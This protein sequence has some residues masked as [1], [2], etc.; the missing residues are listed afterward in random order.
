[1]G[2]A[3]RLSLALGLVLPV[4][5]SP[6]AS[7][8]WMDSSSR[9]ARALAVAA[10]AAGSPAARAGVRVGDAVRQVNGERPHACEAWRVVL[11]NAAERGLAVLL[12]SGRGR[13]TRVAALSATAL[14]AAAP[15]AEPT[16]DVVPDAAATAAGPARVRDVLPDDVAVA[17]TDVIAALEA[18]GPDGRERLEPYR[19]A[20]ADLQRL[21][22][23]LLVR[24]PA[25]DGRRS[26]AAPRAPARRER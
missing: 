13:A 11:E 1:M 26:A 14:A 6:C 4:V 22:T 10:V 24:D 19:D 16:T 5:A 7:R 21:L 15:T 9:L 17:R 18:L 20:V 23:T 25:T 8:R 12:L 3:A 2:D